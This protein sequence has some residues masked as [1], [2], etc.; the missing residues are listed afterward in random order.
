MILQPWGLKPWLK[1]CKAR[2]VS[3]ACCEVRWHEDRARVRCSSS[4][5]WRS[6]CWYPSRA[7]TP[8]D[9]GWSNAGQVER[10]ANQGGVAGAWIADVLL[11][12]FGF[13]AYLFP[14]MIGY[15]GM[16]GLSWPEGDI[17]RAR[18]P[19]RHHSRRR[20][21]GG[22]VRGVRPRDPALPRR[23]ATFPVDAGGII[24]TVVGSGLAGVVNP[25]GGTL[26]L[27][28]LFL[29][30]VTLFTG[31]SWLDVMDVTGRYTIL[32]GERLW[33]GSGGRRANAGPPAGA[34]RSGRSGSRSSASASSRRKPPRIEPVIS[35]V[36]TSARVERERQV[37]LFAPAPG[38]GALPPLALL[39]ETEARSARAVS[40]R[41]A[42]GHLAPGR[43][44]ARGLRHRG[45]GGRGAPRS[46]RHPLRAAAGAGAQG[47]PGDQ[48]GQGP[49]AVALH[50]QRAHRGGHSGQDHHRAGD[51]QR[52]TGGRG[53]ERRAQ[54]QSV[55]HRR[56]PPR[57]G[58]GQ[59]HLGTAGGGGSGEHA[60][61]P[62][63][64]HHRVRQVGRHQRDDPEPALQGVQLRRADDHDRSED[65]GA[66][67]VRGHSAPAGAGG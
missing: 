62:R 52:G 2:R 50:G 17:G 27:L 55:R 43:A 28:A 47:E 40:D 26:F 22:G 16:A 35:K 56:L 42:G 49:R 4:R 24:G 10:I 12:L 7:I 64:G 15:A 66:V 36:E 65:A 48:S 32:V 19:S 8:A 18:R 45:R 13:M 57:A 21:R 9:P 58:P 20:M 30:G 44:Q 41:F 53:P 5:P 11:Y 1:R 3:S 37:P 6:I 25:V 46:R 54:V 61:S 63:G 67:G 60:P 29:T 51:P 34:S 38:S 31:L 23:S 59:G 14:V 33:R 39:D